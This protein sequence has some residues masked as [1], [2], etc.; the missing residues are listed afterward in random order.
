MVTTKVIVEGSIGSCV[1]VTT[2]QSA[3]QSRATKRTCLSQVEAG[4]H[5]HSLHQPMFTT[6]MSA[7]LCD[8]SEDHF[9][10][11]PL[12]SG[13]R[14]LH[15]LQRIQ[16]HC[17]NHQPQLHVRLLS[18]SHQQLPP[19]HQLSRRGRFRQLPIRHHPNS[20]QLRHL[21]DQ[22]SNSRCA[23]CAQNP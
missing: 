15:P 17:V 21:S 5:L 14:A 9:H 18:K 7:Q 10:D 1:C 8:R 19:Q 16:L 22:T 23:P 6:S 3:A 13:C 11:H 2:L 12:N 20:R 4:A